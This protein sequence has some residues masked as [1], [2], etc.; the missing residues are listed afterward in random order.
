[1]ERIFRMYWKHTEEELLLSDS[2]QR[3]NERD[4]ELDRLTLIL[5]PVTY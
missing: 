5:D 2:S 1:M 3:K 4:L